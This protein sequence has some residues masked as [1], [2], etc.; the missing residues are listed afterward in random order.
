MPNADGG[1]V[2]PLLSQ[3]RSCTAEST[4]PESREPKYVQVVPISA[5]AAPE[6]LRIT[7]PPWSAAASNG[8]AALKATGPTWFKA[9]PQPP[10]HTGP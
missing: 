5:T 1:I 7:V 2:G 8:A 4:D 10:G 3:G 9:D 6:S